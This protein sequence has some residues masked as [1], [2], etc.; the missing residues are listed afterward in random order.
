MKKNTR[1]HV[2][3]SAAAD[4]FNRA[5]AR[6]LDRNERLPPEIT[7]TFESAADLLKVLSEQ[8]VRLLR[9]AKKRPIAVSD[10]AVELERDRRA[11]NRDVEVLESFGLLDTHYETNPGHGRRKVVQPRASKF[12]LIANI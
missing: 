3:S 4:F 12:Q 1:F 8:R 11:V 2:T 7:I 5:R 10:L 6:K 9:E